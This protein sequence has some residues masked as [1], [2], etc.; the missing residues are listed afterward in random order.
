MFSLA[1]DFILGRNMKKDLNNKG[2]CDLRIRVHCWLQ[3]LIKMKHTV[4]VDYKT[5]VR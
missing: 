4:K 5:I 3:C 2:I 1:L